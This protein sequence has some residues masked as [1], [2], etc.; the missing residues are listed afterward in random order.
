MN[1]VENFTVN[2]I[3][4]LP[5][6]KG[7][8]IEITGKPIDDSC[9]YTFK[10][11][12]RGN[13]IEHII[14]GDVVA[15]F[16]YDENNKKIHAKDLTNNNEEWYEYNEHGDLIRIKKSSNPDVFISYSYD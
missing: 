1:M 13:L 16:E 6:S 9:N 12:T 5:K 7:K 3:Y 14:D 10:Y 4:G 15:T 8:I 2:E 11:D